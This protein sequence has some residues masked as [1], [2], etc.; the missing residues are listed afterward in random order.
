MC[1]PV[2]ACDSAA[3]HHCA[4]SHLRLSSHGEPFP[5][6]V[7]LQACIHDYRFRHLIEGSA[8]SY[9]AA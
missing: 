2:V 6:L 1:F 7:R 4:D 8:L 3:G 5:L 9:A